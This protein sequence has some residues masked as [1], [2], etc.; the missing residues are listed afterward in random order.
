M[1]VK[2]A[3]S[4][5]DLPGRP[6]QLGLDLNKAY[7]KNGVISMS[8]MHAQITHLRDRDHCPLMQ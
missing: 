8:R 7:I 2:I 5:Q 3:K 1:C 4:M 6:V